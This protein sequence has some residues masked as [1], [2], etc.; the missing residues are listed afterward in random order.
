MSLPRVWEAGG[1]TGS[2]VWI[3]Q[4]LFLLEPSYTPMQVCSVQIEL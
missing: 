3:T 4:L 1:T 2:F